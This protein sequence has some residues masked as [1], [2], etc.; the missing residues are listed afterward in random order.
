MFRR[1]FALMGGVLMVVLMAGTLSASSASA[2]T[3]ANA[4]GKLNTLNLVTRQMTVNTSSGIL[5]LKWNLA[6]HFTRN[7]S[8][9]AARNLVLRDSLALKYDGATKTLTSVTAKGPA[10]TIV[11]GRV[12]FANNGTG[13]VTVGTARVRTSAYTKIARN[14]KVVALNSLTRKDSAV[15]HVA[16]GT[17]KALDMEDNGPEE[18]SVDGTITAISGSSVT[19]APSDGSSP[20]T[21]TA[22]TSTMIEVN[23]EPATLADLQVNMTAEAEYDPTTMVAFSIDAQSEG[24]D[25]EVS[26]TVAAV[27]TTNNTITITPSDGG[28]PVT[29]NV[30]AATEIS[31]N[32]EDATLADVQAG[33][34]VQAEYDS[35]TMTAYEIQAGSDDSGGD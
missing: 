24:E 5:T 15:V 9:A 27:D 23:D 31:V 7:G 33:M 19:I 30:T 18:G 4:S 17:N 2:S 16:A 21:V 28:S 14:G 8:A 11:S 6:T 3:V 34:P 13:V 1:I 12:A 25:Q 29:L 20:V 26:G 22:D 35:A 32:G 10:V